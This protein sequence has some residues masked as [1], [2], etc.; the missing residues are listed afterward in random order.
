MDE[1]Q[2]YVQEISI[3]DIKKFGN[4]IFDLKIERFLF[5]KNYTTKDGE[6]KSIYI[7]PGFPHGKSYFSWSNCIN[8][9]PE[10]EDNEIISYPKR[11]ITPFSERKNEIKWCKDRLDLF[12]S[13]HGIT[14]VNL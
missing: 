3:K 9:I 13:P 6:Q 1:F 8:H 4:L 10:S 2:L 14:K 7:A 12:L 5:Y 11:Y